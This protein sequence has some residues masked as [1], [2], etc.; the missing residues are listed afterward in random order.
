MLV[1]KVLGQAFDSVVKGKH[2]F[3]EPRQLGELCDERPLLL[4]LE[5]HATRNRNRQ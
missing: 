2:L 5:P 3:D 1:G 4:L